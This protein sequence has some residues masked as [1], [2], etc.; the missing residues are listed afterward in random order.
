MWASASRAKPI[1]LRARRLLQSARDRMDA[2]DIDRLETL[3]RDPFDCLKA[4]R[5]LFEDGLEELEAKL[6]AAQPEPEPEPEADVEDDDVADYT[7]LEN[8]RL[9]AIHMLWGKALREAGIEIIVSLEGDD[10]RARISNS[11][12]AIAWFKLA[13]AAFDDEE[14]RSAG[15][16]SPLL[17]PSRFS[18]QAATL[19]IRDSRQGCWARAAIY[20]AGGL[21]TLNWRGLGS[22][23]IKFRRLKHRDARHPGRPEVLGRRSGPWLRTS[24]PERRR[25]CSALA[26]HGDKGA[27]VRVIKD[28]GL[29]PGTGTTRSLRRRAPDLMRRSAKSSPRAGRSSTESRRVNLK[30]P[31]EF[32]RR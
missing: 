6:G 29:Y 1:G 14:C 22:H 9:D 12:K 11:K 13:L 17:S 5:S 7:D 8:N 18:R 25:F 26:R 21:A 31:F 10:A 28:A 27:V 3:A 32:E 24:R 15:R 19:G 2:D 16:R 23:T 30:N 20:E 4:A